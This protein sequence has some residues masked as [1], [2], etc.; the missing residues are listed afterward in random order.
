MTGRP[1]ILCFPESLVKDVIPFVDARYRTLSDREHRAIAGLSMGGAQTLYAAFNN[2]DCFAWVATF[3]A[4][5]PLLPGVSVEIPA[6]P[7]ADRL[8]G[9]DITRTIDPDR[10]I[11]LV[12]NLDAEVN[13]RLRLFYLAIGTEDGLISAHETLKLLLD[14]RGVHYTLVE[15]AGYAHEWRFWRLCLADLAQRLFQG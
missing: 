13:E 5:L 8:R 10:F 12:P 4:G 11:A 9:P 3:S 7:Q 6:P 2:L 15:R 1:G 14:E